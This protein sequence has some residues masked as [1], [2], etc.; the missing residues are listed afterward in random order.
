MGSTP[1]K[2]R[3]VMPSML[4]VCQ[5]GGLEFPCPS[6]GVR[7]VWAQASMPEPMHI[8]SILGSGMVS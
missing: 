3:R 5:N 2:V 6:S 1:S 4:D 8:G 7:L